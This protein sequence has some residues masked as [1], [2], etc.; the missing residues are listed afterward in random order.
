MRTR[1]VSRRQFL[2]GTGTAL[3]VAAVA[4]SLRAQPAAQETALAR[5][6]AERATAA[7]SKITMTINGKA[8]T[9]QVE[10]RWTLAEALRDHAGL[11]GTKIG[12]DRGECGA[13][14][15][16]LDGKP[17]YSCSQL[18]VWADGRAIQTVEG[19]LNDP[20]QQSF[21][22][23]DAPQC[24]FCTS[25]QLMSA[26]ALL[27]ATPHPTA[28]QARAAMT[29]NICRCSG[30]NH[31]IA[32][33]VAAGNA[34][35]VA[36]G[37]QPRD[38][39]PIK[40]SSAD[41]AVTALKTVGHD[42]HRIDAVERTT[43]KATY[44]GDVKVPGMLYARVLRSPHP[45]ARIRR[46]DA[47]K[48]LAL[49]GVKAVISHENCT[50]VWGAGSI[51]GG[52]QYNEEVKK[53]TKHRRYAFNNPVR[54][55][56][57]PVAAV[58]AVDRHTAEEALQLITVEYEPLPFVLDPE[59]A[60]KPGAPQIWPEGNLSPNARNEFV[61][62]GA[63]RGNVQDGFTASDHVFEDRYSTSFVHNAQ[64]EPRSAL[65]VWD[66][67]K[68]TVYTPTGGVANCRTDMARD[69]GIPQENVRVVCRY[70]GG[71]FGNKNQNHD[72]DLIA[73]VLAKNAGAPVMLE[74]S[75]KEDFIGVHGRWPTAQYY[76][77]GVKNDGT[78]Q[79]IQLRGYSGM[80][81][82]R[83]NTGNIAGVELYQ[84][85]HIETSI[86]PVYTNRTVSANFRG[87][88]F[89]QGFF[90]IQ[91]MMDDVAAKLKMDP[92][93]FILKNM[94]RKAG[95]Q[96][97]Y[98]TYSL[99]ECIR[100]GADAFEWK[101]RWKPQP[102]S[103]AGPIK[104]GAG[105]SFMA[106]RAGLGRSSAVVRVD[107]TGKYWVHV[108]VTDVGGGA[109]TT[110]GLIAAEE[111]G[112]P[113]S[114]L[115]V[116]WGDTDRC[117]YSVGESGSRTTIMTGYA[118]VEAARDLKK[119]IAEKGM[120]TGNDVLIANASPN[121]TV[122]G[123]VRSTFGAHFVEVEVDVELGRA[124]VL[125]YLAVHDCGRIINPLTARSQIKGGATMGIGMALHE[126]LVYDQRSG[127]PLSAG[128]YGAR[129]A[130]HRDAPEIE[131]I[132]IESDDGLGP[133]G[134]KSMGESSKVPAPAAVANAVFNAIGVRMKDLPITRDK[135][136]AALA[137][138]TG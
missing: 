59:D 64:M 15:V 90:G 11:T 81:P 134:A 42:T 21:V 27:N 136:V 122:Q 98:T 14:T 89:P 107:A 132:F 35:D 131:I 108:G 118:V 41:S 38:P 119:Q 50:Y 137:P 114:Q 61:P 76:K 3:T 78:L 51:S 95:D 117:P 105:V 129:V 18:A 19:L 77:V 73:A 109:K 70:M 1:R 104:R 28:E 5:Q 16:L 46:I 85:A 22:A 29:G 116:V 127:S 124:R 39:M 86:S 97:P 130:T 100:R 72:A 91:S 47:S 66:A 121:P 12:C 25:G 115:E 93:E 33:T 20:L 92:I 68:L 32:A 23:H 75:R 128:Y 96:T 60:L 34:A 37:F 138:A 82:Y 58:A 7:R 56:G 17:V 133:F 99:E 2:E 63:K 26:K 125:K 54:F 103:G 111:L 52:A 83:K 102:G 84:C 87:P 135:I 8:Q 67:D 31:Y 112:V 40:I 79:A 65:A 126:N 10:D 43:G 94:T 113:L 24:G 13:C 69:L 36:R 9:L 106:F 44:T 123:K 49:P 30:Y 53:I 57:E 71:N 80:G 110:M 101:T 55:V 48:A 62:I 74:L 4:P 120:P 88:E 45:H 6:S